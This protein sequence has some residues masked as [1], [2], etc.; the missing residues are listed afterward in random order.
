MN[1]ILNL[2]RRRRID[3]GIAEEVQAHLDER[4][5]DLLESGMSEA[6][7]RR[8]A[9]R[10]FGNVTLIVQDSREVWRW[11]SV[12]S[13]IRDLRYGI[14]QLRRT[15]GLAAVATVTLGLGI[16]ANTAI[17]SVMNAVILRFLPVP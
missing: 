13:W 11:L 12:E 17:F 3:R 15:P 1:W 6:D 10:E 2:V 5:D 8:Q 4:V 7:A 14:R 9:N 16:G